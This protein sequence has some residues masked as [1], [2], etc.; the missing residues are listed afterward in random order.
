MDN[1]RYSRVTYDIP[2]EQLSYFN[3]RARS[4]LS[5]SSSVTAHVASERRE[6]PKPREAGQYTPQQPSRKQNN[7][8]D[9]PKLT[10]QRGS[11]SDQYQQ[12]F[13]A[14]PRDA[15]GAARSGN[16]EEAQPSHPPPPRHAAAE[17]KSAT[18]IQAA[19]RAMTGQLS[20][21]AVHPTTSRTTAVPSAVARP[22][23]APSATSQTSEAVVA[24]ARSR[25][26][27]EEADGDDYFSGSRNASSVTSRRSVTNEPRKSTA[28][29]DNAR[30]EDRRRPVTEKEV[31]AIPQNAYEQPRDDR[32]IPV[33]RWSASR[34]TPMSRDAP[35]RRSGSAP[36]VDDAE[37]PQRV[38]RAYIPRCAEAIPPVRQQ[39]Q[40]LQSQP[41]A[42]QDFQPQEVGQKM[43]VVKEQDDETERII[44]EEE[45]CT[46]QPQVNDPQQR[47]DSNYH[48]SPYRGSQ[49]TIP[50]R[51]SRGDRDQGPFDTLYSDAE[52]ARQ[53]SR[54]RMQRASEDA[55][56]KINEKYGPRSTAVNPQR[57]AVER[58]V[59]QEEVFAR[60]YADAQRYNREKAEQER[61]IERKRQEERAEAPFDWNKGKSHKEIVM[62]GDDETPPKPRRSPSSQRPLKNM[63]VFERLARPINVTL[64]FQKQKE[65]EEQA[66][67]ER[68]HREQEQKKSEME[69]IAAYDWG[70]PAKSFTFADLKSQNAMYAS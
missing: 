3:P 30:R 16:A 13:A 25:R 32:Q 36:S 62:S 27:A 66:K 10:A 48:D 57:L 40:Q 39:Q 5:G 45:N 47:R 54:R 64:S 53:S 70:I 8:D 63:E 7:D 23:Y 41:K 42:Q 28:P 52:S 50:P 61:S 11:L 60:L 34:G 55:E 21:E 22:A 1:Q 33:R 38:P 56:L 58:D 35:S 31:P 26:A 68:E 2:Q 14:W 59:R 43:P 9:S 37:V 15:A 4:S 65:L 29:A 44:D 51:D 18:A 6:V 46:F 24:N 12:Y 69:K 49:G 67:Q 19:P 17:A 20:Q